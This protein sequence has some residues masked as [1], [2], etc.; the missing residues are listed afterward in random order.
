MRMTL[1]IDDDVLAAARTLAKR[2]GSSLGSALSELARRGYEGPAT[3]RVPVEAQTITR[4]DVD[5]ALSDWP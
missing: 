2:N 1:D 3:F 4:E 5:R